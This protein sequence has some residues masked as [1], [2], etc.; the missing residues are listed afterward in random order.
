[1][2][3]ALWLGF[4]LASIGVSVWRWNTFWC[5]APLLVG[6]AFGAYYGFVIGRER[7]DIALAGLLAGGIFWFAVWVQLRRR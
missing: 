1:M 2:E 6:G 7:L 4:F 3:Y 5:Y